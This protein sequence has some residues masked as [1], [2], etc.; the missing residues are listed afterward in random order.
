[1]LQTSENYNSTGNKHNTNYETEYT[2]YLVDCSMC[3][4]QYV[5]KNKIPFNIRLNNHRKDVKVRKVILAVKHSK[6]VVIDLTNTQ[7]SR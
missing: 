2:I 1:M 5:G 7:V 3:K 4:L 6:K